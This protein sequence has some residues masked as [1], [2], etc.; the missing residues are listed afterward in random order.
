MV[1]HF[2]FVW[3]YFIAYIGQLSC[4]RPHNYGVNLILILIKKYNEMHGGKE[5]ARG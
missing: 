5:N 3:I 2:G 4:S 1:I